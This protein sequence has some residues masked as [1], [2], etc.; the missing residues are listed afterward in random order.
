MTLANS[1]RREGDAFQARVFWMH[2]A[3]LLLPDS[4]MVSV[5][6]EIGPK[7][8]DDIWVEYDARRAREHVGHRVLREHIQCKWHV[9]LDEYGYAD[10]VRPDFINA[11]TV[12]FLEKAHAAQLACSTGDDGVLFKLLTNWTV[13]KAD[14][15]RPLIRQRSGAL[16][17][18]H[19]FDGSTDRSARGQLRKAWRDHLNV[20]DDG[21]RR[22]AS[23]LSFGVARDTLDGA[24]EM[25]DIYFRL[26]GLRRIPA[27]ESSFIYDDLPF[28]W[29]SQ[30][31][32]QFG[33]SELREACLT[34]GLLEGAPGER[35]TFG[36]KSFEHA[37]DRL[38]GRCCKVLNLVDSFDTR[39]IREQ[40]DW[41]ADL[42]PR[43][44]AFLTDA[45]R[46]NEALRLVLD[47]HLTLAFAA[48]S[49][50]NIKSGRDVEL[51]QRTLGSDVWRTDDEV[52]TM[53]HARWQLEGTIWEPTAADIAVA[54]SLTHD[55]SAAMQ[56]FIER[57]A[58][59]VHTV[60]RAAPDC[61][62]SNTAIKS[63]AHAFA[64]AEQLVAQIR[65]E[66][67]KLQ[68]PGVV[69]LFIAAPVA[70]AFFLGQRHVSIG[71]LTLYEFDFENQRGNDY[72]A[73]LS[74][75]V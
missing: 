20:D 55:V 16:N 12:S 21:L 27:N 37:F 63:G 61:G 48:G 8:F 18:E 51:A 29:L 17:L 23:T 49:I 13:A 60:L 72:C 59:P 65:A 71:K 41:K 66:K 64:L 2:A 40:N 75:P 1:A 35:R 15:L 14:A 47:T 25:L 57:T 45:A 69:H 9:T 50:V 73:S 26:A 62:S 7:G 30:G 36:V 24:R 54:V 33:Q 19:L 32:L 11:S 31:K 70:F 44:T 39:Y 53:N 74:L 52:L 42:Y 67:Q 6:F 46:N 22:L 3:Q 34:Q 68:R 56:S 58:L 43:L 4:H 5:G 10:L 28:Q 38:E